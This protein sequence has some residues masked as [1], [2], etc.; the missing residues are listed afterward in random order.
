MTTLEIATKLAAYCRKGEFGAAQKELY[1]ADVISIEPMA[2]A[3]YDKE[4][5]GLH[6]VQEKIKKFMGTIETSYGNKVSEPLVTGNV[7]AFTLDMDVAMKGKP[8]SNFTELCVYQVKDGK[9]ISEQFF[10]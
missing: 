8:R 1:A 6:A 7:F 10:M 9:V 4:T 3:Q 2:T 5:K